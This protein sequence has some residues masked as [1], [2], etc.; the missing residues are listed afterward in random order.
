MGVMISA[1]ITV[2]IF[3]CSYSSAVSTALLAEDAVLDADLADVVEQRADPD[4]VLDLLG[5]PE[6][7]GDGAADSAAT[8][9]EWPRV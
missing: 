9:S 1:P 7:A 8:R 4:L 5:Q 2:C 3:I 6:V